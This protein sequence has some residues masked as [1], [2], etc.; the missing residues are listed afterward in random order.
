[1]G[2]PMP[3]SLMSA[4]YAEADRY[5]WIVSEQLG[6]D[7]G[8]GAIDEWFEK[9][10]RGFVRARMVEHV[11][12]M[13]YYT[14]FGDECFGVAERLRPVQPQLVDWLIEQLQQGAENLDIL[15][16]AQ[17]LN[18]PRSELFAILAV[19]DVN[20]WRFPPVSSYAG[21]HAS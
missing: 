8:P 10:W 13:K 17:D 12:G 3:E 16:H 9:Y 20:A 2:M 15:V 1:M 18:L 19:V 11:L 6:R 5:K 7:A 21:A 14:E 4:A